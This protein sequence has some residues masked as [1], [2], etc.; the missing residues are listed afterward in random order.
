MKRPPRPNNWRTTDPGVFWSIKIELSEFYGCNL[1]GCYYD[2][3]MNRGDRSYGSFIRLLLF[4][5]RLMGGIRDKKLKKKYFDN[6]KTSYNRAIKE[7][8]FN[9]LCHSKSTD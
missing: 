1:G 9:L 8:L 2:V 5:L 3:R 4:I 6:P 7:D